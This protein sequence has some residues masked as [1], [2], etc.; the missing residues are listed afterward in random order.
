MKII[1][2]TLLSFFFFLIINISLQASNSIPPFIESLQN[3][4]TLDGIVDNDSSEPFTCTIGK[5]VVKIIKIKD[6][7]K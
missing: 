1:S 4:F 7:L 2:K 5:S 6:G 3:S